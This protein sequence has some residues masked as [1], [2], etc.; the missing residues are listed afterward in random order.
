MNMNFSRNCGR[1]TAD[2]VLLVE[3]YKNAGGC[4]LSILHGH[5]KGIVILAEKSILS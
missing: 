1:V 5:S 4:Y 2:I 3:A